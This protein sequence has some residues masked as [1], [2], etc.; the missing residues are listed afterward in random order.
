MIVS[1]RLAV[2]KL[3]RPINEGVAD[4]YDTLVWVQKRVYKNPVKAYMTVN[5]R[6]VLG[7][8]HLVGYGVGKWLVNNRI[9]LKT[10]NEIYAD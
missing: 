1:H 10:W 9:D 5:I 2:V 8:A 3:L 4:P 7:M 6:S